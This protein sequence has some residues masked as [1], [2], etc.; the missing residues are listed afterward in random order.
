[1]SPYPALAGLRIGC[2]QYLNSK[3]LIADYRGPVLFDHPS[4]LAAALKRGELDAALVPIF[5]A[6]S[7][8]RYVAADGVAIASD[9]PVYSVYLAYEGELKRV[10][11]IAL[12]PAS[13]TSAH[14]VQVLLR[15][16]HGIQPVC[17][18]SKDVNAADARL[19]IGNQAIEYRRTAPPGIRFLDLG[20]EWKRCTGLPFVY[21]VWLLRP[22]LKD[23]AEIACEFRQ[24]K[25]RGMK[26]INQIAG[27]EK[28]IC[29]DLALRYL[30]EHIRFE[31]GAREKHAIE[32]Y[33]RLLCVHGFVPAG[34]EPLRYV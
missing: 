29:P 31:L 8:G 17:S 20:E 6:L 9:G 3:P 15:E 14:L 16:F 24:L 25:T 19:L 1:V 12:D 10:K 34:G 18:A 27:V 7:G 23:L 11:S 21:A 32:E 13:L 4:S 28:A 30:T 2:V 5:E 33:R 22:E 26:L